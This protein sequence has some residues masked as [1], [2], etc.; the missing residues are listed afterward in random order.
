MSAPH[1]AARLAEL[2]ARREAVAA[3]RRQVT[4][5]PLDPQ[6]R[7]ATR[8][9]VLACY[10]YILG[11]EPENEAAVAQHAGTISLG[12]LRALFLNAEEFRQTLGRASPT[13]EGPPP[14][15]DAEA[16]S[17]VLDTLLAWQRD[18]WARLGEQAPHW[19]VRP[20]ARFLPDAIGRNL[21]A[22]RATGAADAIALLAVLA[23]QGLDPA[24]LPHVLEHG[25]G[26]G[27]V[28]PFL[29]QHFPDITAV[30]VSAPHLAL[31]RDQARARGLMHI[32]WLRA[33]PGL[34]LP[35]DGYDL[36]YSRRVLQWNPPPLILHTLRLAF[37][38]L[39]PGGLAVFQVPTWCAGYAF[40]PAA[41]LA[42]APPDGPALHLLPQADIFA[43]AAAAGL[44]VLDVREDSH[45]DDP[46]PTPL[47]SQLFVLRKPG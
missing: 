22:F 2:A 44:A 19:S 23:R 8:E 24:D 5:P 38:G 46:G 26:I 18:V 10:R 25:C 47:R 3:R 41:H 16:A 31:A 42:A 39:K 4:A 33:G 7:P 28:T 13:A 29:A 15:V 14:R 34:A 40:D 37:A 21:A 6:A 9:D 17:D 35:G 12:G 32:R 43:A 27:R 45:R 20:E 1:R 11:R 30:D 36:W